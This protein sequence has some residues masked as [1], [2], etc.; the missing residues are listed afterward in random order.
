MTRPL[1]WRRFPAKERPC[2]KRRVKVLRLLSAMLATALS[3]GPHASPGATLENFHVGNWLVGAY[4]DDSTGQ[5]SHCGMSASYRSGILMIFTIGRDFRWY[6][7]FYDPQ[8]AL[9]PGASYDL[10]MQID[11]RGQIPARATALTTQMVAIPLQDNVAL[12]E[13][14]RHGYQLRVDAAGRNFF[15]N[16]DGTAR[17]LT[18]V[19]NCT[20][21]YVAAATPSLDSNPFIASS[22]QP[23]ATG[24]ASLRAEATTFAAN[25]LSQA[26]VS[27]FRIMQENETPKEWANFDVVWTAPAVI[28]MVDIIPS[29]ATLRV[30]EIRA[31]IV[32]SDARSCKGKFASGAVPEGDSNGQSGAGE[33]FTAC[34]A[35]PAGWAV[36]YTLVPRSNGGFYL[37]GTIGS[38]TNTEPA[39]TAED[40]IRMAAQK[41]PP[42]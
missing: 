29:Q 37:V 22:G 1:D 16:L 6:V 17:G 9:T 18:A 21:R 32:A 10:T 27:G 31:N 20:H 36:Y 35:A 11:G 39:R 23:G 30:D 2:A 25:L 42:P 5:F 34:D 3:L 8:W 12:F 7:D 40:S 15:F 41:A 26:G 28:G 38:G 24:R 19:L 14:F 13:R 33:F 4:S